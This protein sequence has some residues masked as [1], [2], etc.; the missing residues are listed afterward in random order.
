M[1]YRGL[2]S[3]RAF[4]R[5][6]GLTKLGQAAFSMPARALTGLVK[7]ASLEPMDARHERRPTITN[8][9]RYFNT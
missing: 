2:I 8:S 4:S 5:W 3:V 9:F 1:R 6:I 7:G